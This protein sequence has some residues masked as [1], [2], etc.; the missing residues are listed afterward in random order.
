MDVRI[1]QARQHG[2]IFAVEKLRVRS[3]LFQDVLIAADAKDLAAADSQC[4]L[5]GESFIDRDDFTV[6]QDQVRLLSGTNRGERRDR[7]TDEADDSRAAKHDT[8]SEACES[9]QSRR[10]KTITPFVCLKKG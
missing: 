4:L 7:Q 6:V 3:L 2:L 10:D 9:R 5:K 1:D 8:V